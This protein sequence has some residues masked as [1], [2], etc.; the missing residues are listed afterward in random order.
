MPSTT[1]HPTEPT[2]PAANTWEHDAAYCASK[3]ALLQLTRAIALD[4]AARNIRANCVCPGVIDTPMVH[5]FVN[6]ADNPA[7]VRRE[8]E[9]LSPLK[10]LGTAREIANCI[11]FLASDE[12]SFVT[13]TT[14]VA[15]GGTIIQP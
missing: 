1:A 12:A 2:P 8:Y 10:R 3:G 9:A 6:Q 4:V 7:D 13:G 11:L 15:D 14:L 5:A